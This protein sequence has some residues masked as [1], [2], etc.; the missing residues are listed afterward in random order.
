MTPKTRGQARADG[1]IIDV[2]VAGNTLSATLT[3]TTAANAFLTSTGSASQSFH[4]VQEFEL[5][6]SDLSVKAAD[7]TL[8]SALVGYIRSRHKA[9]ASMVKACAEVS[10]LT[11]NVVAPAMLISHPAQAVEGN[12]GRLCNQHLPPV[13]VAG[14]PMG[15]YV[16]VAD[17]I[18]TA[19]GGGVCD[20]HGVADFSPTTA[21]PADWVR[22]RDPFQG[23]DKKNFGF[24]LS[25]A[26]DPADSGQPAAAKPVASGVVRTSAT[27]PSAA[28]TG[29]NASLLGD[30]RALNAASLPPKNRPMF[31]P[32]KK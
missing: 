24:T 7:L 4:L 26:A 14:L 17:F 2:S 28:S 30:N 25:L 20:G 21:L 22:L 29:R 12:D 1:G 6:C 16:M 13:K 18:I 10:P 8:D 23:V 27:L 31:F 11:E 3:G 19:E 5:A 15:R 32:V 9:G